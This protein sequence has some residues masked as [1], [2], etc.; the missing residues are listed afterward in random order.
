MSVAALAAPGHKGAPEFV[1]QLTEDK[2][3]SVVFIRY[4]PDFQASKP[5]DNDGTCDPDEKWQFCSDCSKPGGDEEPPEPSPSGCY[6]FLTSSKPKWNWVEE[7]Y[8]SDDLETVSDWATSVWEGA[9]SADIFGNAVA[10]D[11]P[12][13]VY[14]YKNAVTYYD[15][16]EE[17]VIGVTKI[18]FRGK[19]IYEYDIALDTDYFPETTYDL[20]TVVLH[21]FGHAAGLG[22]LYDTV[23]MEE[24]MY[25]HYE[26]PKLDLR[27][28]DIV[29]IQLL[30]GA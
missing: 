26:G 24:V 7:Y 2:L 8:Y 12:W 9:T 15:Y 4:T 27:D 14:D 25:W 3:T 5:C 13:G 1:P 11:Y 28:G 19:N 22:D 21:E 20:N 30:Y 16:P 23:C 10:E 17:G 29:G 18:W 6:A